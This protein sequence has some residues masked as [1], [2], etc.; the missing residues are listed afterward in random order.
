MKFIK[1]PSGTFLNLDT[2]VLTGKL[3]GEDRVFVKTT[4]NQ[5]FLFSGEDKDFIIGILLAVT[6][7]NVDEI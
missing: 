6:A 5:E 1:L 4:A 2:V 7:N 3:I